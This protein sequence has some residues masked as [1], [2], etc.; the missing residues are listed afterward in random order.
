MTL[1]SKVSVHLTQ[2]ALDDIFE[3]HG[4]SIRRWGRKTADRY[5]T[6]I[7]T[8]LERLKV[9]PGLLATDNDIVPFFQFYQ[10]NKHLLVC[11]SRE[12]DVVVLTVLHSSMDIPTRLHELQ[13]L[14]STELQVLHEKLR[15]KR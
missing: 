4:H 10:V 11:D 12:Q 2:R 13:P 14:L 6:D 5:I 9:N 15:R 3:V 7:E 1:R 8:A